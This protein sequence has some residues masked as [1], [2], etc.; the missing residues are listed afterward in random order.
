MNKNWT[1]NLKIKIF[2]LNIILLLASCTVIGEWWYNK[3]DN[4]LANYFFEYADF[5]KEQKKYIKNTTTEFHI[6]HKKN[7]LPKYKMLLKELKDLGTNI[8]TEE[9]ENL[10]LSTYE[11]F[12]SSNYFFLP[13]QIEFSKNLSQ[14][15]TDQIESH[16]D[17][18]IKKRK[19]NFERS[20]NNFRETAIKNSIDGFRRLGIKLNTK[21]QK[22][23]VDNMNS[24]IDIREI[25][26]KLQEQWYE[27]LIRILSNNKEEEFSL[28]LRKHLA[29]IED[30]GDENHR[31]N[32]EKNREI[33]LRNISETLN[34]FTKNQRDNYA[35][36]IDFY[37]NLIDEVI[38][39]DNHQYKEIK[40]A[41]E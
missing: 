36:R 8:S 33:F 13:Y 25:S 6:W 35:R 27:E 31:L 5:S 23:I 20:K 15:Q 22:E 37:I 28:N 4:Y 38:N 16:F 26:I 10:Y 1:K 2:F 12:K 9:V 24:L 30:G 18:I 17:E 29:N 41:N 34:S 32:E 21:Q 19:E 14:I 3:L 7:E 39:N 11:L 40:T